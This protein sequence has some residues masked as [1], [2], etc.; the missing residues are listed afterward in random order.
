MVVTGSQE[1]D[2]PQHSVSRLKEMGNPEGTS[3]KRGWKGRG[4]TGTR[5]AFPLCFPYPPQ[6]GLLL[7]PEH[8]M[9]SIQAPCSHEMIKN[10]WIN[11]DIAFYTHISKI[12]TV[13]T[14]PLT[15]VVFILNKPDMGQWC[16]FVSNSFLTEVIKGRLTLGLYQELLACCCSSHPSSSLFCLPYPCSHRCLAPGTAEYTVPHSAGTL[17]EERLLLLELYTLFIAQ[18]K[19]HWIKLRR[20]M[21]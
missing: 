8:W 9:L 21:K 11:S 4:N 2:G 18:H 12:I 5:R 16:L 7:G 17:G 6:C 3:V 20:R 10:K 15:L 14:V 13:K 19:A 1:V